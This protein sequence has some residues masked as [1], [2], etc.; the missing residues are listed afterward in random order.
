M[1][2]WVERG[3]RREVEGPWALV[4][5]SEVPEVLHGALQGSLVPDSSL[6]LR[7]LNPVWLIQRLARFGFSGRLPVFST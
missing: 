5:L 4:D 2:L 6:N 7:Q 1:L 3:V